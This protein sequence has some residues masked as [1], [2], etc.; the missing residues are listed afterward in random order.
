MKGLSPIPSLA[1]FRFLPVKNIM[2]K[3]FD[4]NIKFLIAFCFNYLI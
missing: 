3:A 1:D 2:A 4:K